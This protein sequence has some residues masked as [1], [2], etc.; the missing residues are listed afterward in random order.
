MS[1]PI[2]DNISIH[3]PRERSDDLESVSK[4]ELEISIHAP[5]ERSDEV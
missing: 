2:Q 1:Q 5:R 4:R 3:A